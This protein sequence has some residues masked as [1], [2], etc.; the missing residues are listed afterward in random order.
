MGYIEHGDHQIIPV[1]RVYEHKEMTTLPDTDALL[2]R[3]GAIATPLLSLAERIS[4]ARKPTDYH[5]EPANPPSALPGLIG[6][7]REANFSP[8]TPPSVSLFRSDDP[9]TVYAEHLKGANFIVR[10]APDGGEKVHEQVR[11]LYLGI[12]LDEEER[13]TGTNVLRTISP[14]EKDISSIS[15]T[16]PI[17]PDEL[18]E[19]LDILDHPVLVRAERHPEPKAID[20]ERKRRNTQMMA[21]TAALRDQIRR[22]LEERQKKY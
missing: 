20:Q 1:P 22:E 11:K 14:L 8:D 2:T 7:L 21:D 13:I 19:I 9:Q 10:Y 15:P 3:I 4:L 17:T 18:A 16:S 6:Q 5:V 12:Y